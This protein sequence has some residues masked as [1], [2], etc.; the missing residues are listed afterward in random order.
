VFGGPFAVPHRVVCATLAACAALAT[1]AAL[2]ACGTP[3]ELRPKP[4]S[5]VPR[6]SD[7]P[8]P[9]EATDLPPNLVLPPGATAPASPLPS[10]A[11]EFATP[12]A[13]YPT[14]EQVIALVRRAGGLLPRTGTV[15]VSRGPLCAGTW[16][17]TVFSVPGKESLQVVSRGTPG[18]L[19]MVTAGTDVCSIRVITAA[20][21]GIRNI[22]V[23][24]SPES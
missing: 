15:P 2:A 23:C 20:P 1:C 24:P 11:E 12:C 6:P 13:G 16:Q 4:G 17:Y 18:D 5:S 14:A 19:T 9:S 10:F 21:T 22:A 3:P 7:M 8:S